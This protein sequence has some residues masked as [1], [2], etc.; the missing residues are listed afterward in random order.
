[1]TN[2]GT[3]INCKRCGYFFREVEAV[4]TVMGANQGIPISTEAPPNFSPPQQVRPAP[5]QFQPNYQSQTQSN[6]RYNHQNSPARKIK[7][8]VFS[9]ILGIL[10]F[11]VINMIFGV[12]LSLV[13][14][15]ILGSTGAVIGVVITLTIL[16][17]GLITGITALVRANKRPQE[18][19]GKG[20]AIAGIVLS[21][22]GILVLPLVAA[23][24]IPNVLAARRAAN[25]GSAISSL[26]TLAAA[27]E[28]YRATK[29]TQIC[30]DL[31]ELVQAKLI[32]PS[33]GGGN[34][35]GYVLVIAKL[36]QGCEIFA[37]PTEAK[38]VSATGFRSF[39][40]STEDGVLRAG[41]KNGQLASKIDSPLDTDFPA[42]EPTS[43]PKIASQR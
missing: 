32:D 10:S 43:K 38:G 41:N 16:P 7:M 20:L 42:N 21:S 19:G 18:Y 40:Y 17:T 8:A 30:G 3:A 9:L 1:L 14:A 24:A 23:I 22:F 6:Y 25:E 29:T 28:T 27:Q 34:K 31:G 12:V 13:L 35:N 11:P 15:L 26:K 36:P 33:L 5:N 4:E 39:Y 37:T 2:W